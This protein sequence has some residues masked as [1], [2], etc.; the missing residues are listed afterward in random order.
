[1][2]LY[3]Y[4]LR[5]LYL[6][7]RAH[8]FRTFI[9]ELTR[10]IGLKSQSTLFPNKVVVHCVRML[11]VPNSYDDL[12][13]DEDEFKAF[14]REGMKRERGGGGRERERGRERGK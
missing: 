14:R 6:I 3:D 2:L 13:M 1:M 7:Y 10:N 4:F 5:L 9:L 12:D 8:H 11:H